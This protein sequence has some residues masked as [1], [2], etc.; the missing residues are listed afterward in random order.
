MTM[1]RKKPI[2]VEA[3]RFDGSNEKAIEDWMNAFDR[4]E[5][6]PRMTARRFPE[7]SWVMI[8]M[9]DKIM[10]LDVGYWLARDERGLFY[11]CTPGYFAA[12]HELA[13]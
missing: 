6:N 3:I 12:T 2:V 10:T 5:G 8:V 11:P 4:G 9:E 7:V 1:F 13:E